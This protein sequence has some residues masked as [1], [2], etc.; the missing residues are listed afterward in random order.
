MPPLVVC[1][2][3]LNL[4]GFELEA[5]DAELVVMFEDLAA[6]A[7]TEEELAE[8]LRERVRAG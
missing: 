5:D 8:W 6:G 1:E 3:L 7:V 4:N 2:T